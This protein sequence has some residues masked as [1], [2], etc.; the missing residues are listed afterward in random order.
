MNDLCSFLFCLALGVAARL[1][2]LAT[3]AL[4]RRTDILPVTFVLDAMIVPTVGGAFILYIIFTGT[5]LAPYMFSAA[6]TGYLIAYK[7]TEKKPPKK[8]DTAAAR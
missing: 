1:L 6:L 7:L 4:A 5:A 8:Q 2:Y 3:T